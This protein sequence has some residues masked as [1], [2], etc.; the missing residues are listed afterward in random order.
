MSPATTSIRTWDAQKIQQ[1]LKWTIYTLLLINFAFYIGEDWNRIAYTLTA[2]S[3]ILD[4]TAEFATSI[5][6]VG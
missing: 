2:K 1:V 5:D 4:W 6:Y 3:T